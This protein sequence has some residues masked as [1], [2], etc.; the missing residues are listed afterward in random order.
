MT[1]SISPKERELAKEIRERFG[2]QEDEPQGILLIKR[3]L[4][5]GE[6]DALLLDTGGSDKLGSSLD[7]GAGAKAEEIREELLDAISIFYFAE[8][9]A[10][11]RCVTAMVRVA[12]SADSGELEGESEQDTAATIQ[13]IATSAWEAL[14]ASA[15]AV[16]DAATVGISQGTSSSTAYGHLCLTHF[17]E[18]LLQASLPSQSVRESRRY[19][20]FWATQILQQQVEILHLLVLI[21]YDAGAM[22]TGPDAR[23]AVRVLQCVQRSEFG[24]L[25]TSGDVGIFAAASPEG[26]EWGKAVKALLTL[27]AVESIGVEMLL[28]ADECLVSLLPIQDTSAAAKTGNQ[29]KSAMASQSKKRGSA[30][31]EK[32]DDDENEHAASDR[33]MQR[34]RHG[35]AE[36]AQAQAMRVKPAREGGAASLAANVDLLG[37]ALDILEELR[38]DVHWGPILLAWSLLLNRIEMALD[39]ARQDDSTGALPR[40]LEPL[41]RAIDPGSLSLPAIWTKLANLAFHPSMQLNVTLA[42]LVEWLGGTGRTGILSDRPAPGARRQAAVVAGGIL[43]STSVAA[44]PL[45]YRAVLKGVLLAQTEII[46]PEFIADQD[47]LVH[48]WETVMGQADVLDESL[49]AGLA[50]LVEQFWQVD[51][52]RYET[53]AS[54]LKMTTTRWPIVFTPLL[55]LLK[56]LTGRHTRPYQGSS[57][58]FQ[59]AAATHS[60]GVVLDFFANLP[61]IAHFL[62]AK[63]SVGNVYETITTMDT[64]DGSPSIAYRL[65]RDWPIFGR[66]NVLPQGT[67]GRVVS[68][69]D[70]AVTVV[71]HLD[72][73]QEADGDDSSEQRRGFSGWRLLT[74]VLASLVGLSEDEEADEID[75]DT[76]NILAPKKQVQGPNDLAAL[77]PDA[78]PEER[79]DIVIDSLE[80]LSAVLSAGHAT[81]LDLLAHLAGSDRSFLHSNDHHTASVD[82]EAATRAANRLTR[83]TVRVLSLALAERQI[84]TRLVSVCY[85]LITHLL[86]VRPSCVWL[87]LRPSN[88]LVGSPG[89]LSLRRDAADVGENRSV[90]LE[91]ET[92]GATYPATLALLDLHTALLLEAQQSHFS[93]PHPLLELKA[94]VVSRVLNWLCESVWADA[95]HWRYQSGAE[96]K[97]EILRKSVRMFNIV[98]SDKTLRS[99]DAGNPLGKAFQIVQANFLTAATPLLVNPL[100]PILSC[101]NSLHASVARSDG[102][103]VAT[104]ASQLVRAT[105]SL[106]TRLV[107]R[108]RDINATAPALK[109]RIGPV[110]A[111]LFDPVPVSQELVR[112]STATS[113]HAV[114]IAATLVDSIIVIHSADAAALLMEATCAVADVADATDLPPVSLIAA[115]GSSADVKNRLASLLM[116]A[117]DPEGVSTLSASIWL[118]LAAWVR[119]QP[120]L[121]GMMITGK[122]QLQT[123]SE[124]AQAETALDVAF[125]LL[126]RWEELWIKDVT[127]LECVLKFANASWTHSAQYGSVF[128]VIA[129]KKELWSK[130]IQ[131]AGQDEEKGLQED[132]LQIKTIRLACKTQALQLISRAIGPT[133]LSKG[134]STRQ[135]LRAVIDT[136]TNTTAFEGIVSNAF[137][138]DIDA[139][140]IEQSMSGLQSFA[141]GLPFE[142]LRNPPLRDDLDMSRQFGDSYV[143]DLALL[144]SKLVGFQS[145]DPDALDHGKRVDVYNAEQIIRLVVLVNREWSTLDSKIFHLRA[146]RELLSASSGPVLGSVWTDKSRLQSVRSTAFAAWLKVISQ[147]PPQNSSGG[148][149]GEGIRKAQL[150][151]SAALLEIAWGGSEAQT[152]AKPE[153][154]VAALAHLQSV[155]EAS[156]ASLEASLTGRLPEPYH[157]DLFQMVLLAS[158]RYRDLVQAQKTKLTL[159]AKQHREMHKAIDTFALHVV[160]A[161]RVVADYASPT[162]A[163]AAREEFPQR[164]EIEADIG[165]LA[166]ILDVLIRPEADLSP[167]FLAATFQTTSVLPACIELFVACPQ[168]SMGAGATTI[169]TA[170]LSLFL[171]FSSHP[172]ISELAVLSGL[173]TALSNNASTASLEAGA[174]QSYVEN[175]YR[176]IQHECW[177]L[178]LRIVSSLTMS[179]SERLEPATSQNFVVTEIYGFAQLYQAQLDKMFNF[180][181]IATSAP[182][183]FGANGAGGGGGEQR[184]LT[185]AD[186]EEAEAGVHL[187]VFLTQYFPTDPFFQVLLSKLVRSCAYL[188]Q[189]SSYLLLRPMLLASTFGAEVAEDASQ[190]EKKLAAAA[191]VSIQE[192]MENVV[193]GCIA[194]ISNFTNSAGIICSDPAELSTNEL[195]IHPVS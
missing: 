140:L 186:L 153:S 77:T 177:I 84:N 70:Q 109:A 181:P 17:Q 25:A 144:G 133:P 180:D 47:A 184:P 113:R 191:K 81:S 30:R 76:S 73:S 131:L 19:A 183:P 116:L 75:P 174:V 39:Q 27:L 118:L 26:V 57:S 155:L 136:F 101:S 110:E 104:V 83:I 28:D 134:S 15:S 163:A 32:G 145:T 90:L 159:N 102:P 48:A 188:L 171:T 120:A 172:A 56:V 166:G 178:M 18:H 33:P 8:K 82:I 59:S 42:M 68:D 89:L 189:R 162:V 49:R 38:F 125:R 146:L 45:A 29:P 44:S 164:Q 111:M 168:M 119:H 147:T 154:V 128:D 105:L 121:A 20:S 106:C 187:L 60:A 193:M 152:A 36:P 170:L 143:F 175:G 148:L 79:M 182:P 11:I 115:L 100:V 179:F 138:F 16:S 46:K 117:D 96:H 165:I 157:Q 41:A 74:D 98:L 86:E 107:Q 35:A 54:V 40:H 124:Q 161:L 132:E 66:R 94:W 3:F 130:L 21:F 37:E 1:L 195:L 108:T 122:S 23:W 127:A 67:V 149:V 14:L 137:A 190:Q 7:A 142:L 93:A 58:A 192:R 5:T 61:S 167:H 65:V 99:A 151:T 97:I 135:A 95:L 50:A 51:W 52:E 88:V 150:H 169:P 92:Q 129:D 22:A 62:P 71:W 9:L 139:Q 13:P 69:S 156:E 194:A 64:D 85:T 158:L 53:R 160:S 24:A 173:M 80:L 10:V 6:A 72:Q 123:T 91:A 141:P 2:L 112:L 103:L 78:S 43:A 185:E 4:H 12:A 87:A 55:R 126:Q 114:Q 176:S 31:E 34:Q 63:Q